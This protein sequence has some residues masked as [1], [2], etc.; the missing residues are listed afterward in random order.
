[1]TKIGRKAGTEAGLNFEIAN[2][3]GIPLLAED[4]DDLPQT[5]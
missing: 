2:L 5:G 3:P 4:S 1:M